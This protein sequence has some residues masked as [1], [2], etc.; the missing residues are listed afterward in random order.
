MGKG[1]G[2]TGNEGGGREKRKGR[3]ENERGGRYCQVD[4]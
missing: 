4:S 1:E 3:G 2:G